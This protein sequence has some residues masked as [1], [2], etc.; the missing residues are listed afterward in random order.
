MR[1]VPLPPL[2]SLIARGWG[3]QVCLQPITKW[4]F[5]LLV[6]NCGIHQF[7][8]NPFIGVVFGSPAFG[9]P[10]I[11]YFNGFSPQ[12]QLELEIGQA[13]WLLTWWFS[14]LEQDH[15]PKFLFPINPTDLEGLVFFNFDYIIFCGLMGEVYLLRFPIRIPQPLAPGTRPH[16]Q[17]VPFHRPSWVWQRSSFSPAEVSAWALQQRHQELREGALNNR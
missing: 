6:W 1:N 15:G 12:V 7:A 11:G 16:D 13:P 9:S 17:F 14:S 2:Q 3:K 4:R 5:G 10:A 8:T